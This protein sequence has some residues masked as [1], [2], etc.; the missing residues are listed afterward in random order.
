[1]ASSLDSPNT[2]RQLRAKV[3]WLDLL[4]GIEEFL[5]TTLASESL[6]L[7]AEEK[8]QYFVERLDIL[9]LPPSIPPRPG[10]RSAHGSQNELD[11][12][13]EATD[14]VPD[15]FAAYQ[16]ELARTFAQVPPPAKKE[17][18]SEHV[19]IYD[20]IDSS[21]SSHEEDKEH[22]LYEIPVVRQSDESCPPCS[23]PNDSASLATAASIDDITEEVADTCPP[24]PLPPRRDRTVSE[25]T[26]RSTESIASSG[27]PPDLP[28]RPLLHARNSDNSSVTEKLT[29]SQKSQNGVVDGDSTSYE[30]YDEEEK[31]NDVAL[32]NKLNIKLPK[33][34]KKESNR[35]KK[36]LSSSRSSNQ[37]ELN[38]PYKSLS[39]VV[40]SGDLYYRGKLSWNR[41][42]VALVN[43]NLVC[44]KPDK[45]TRPNLVIH[46]PGYEATCT[47]RDSKKGFEIKLS[48]PNCDA[49]YFS[50]DF[51][52]WAQTWCDNINKMSRG[53]S[54]PGSH[55]HLARSF[56]GNND[57][58]YPSF[59]GSKPELNSSNS[60]ISNASSDGLNEDAKR[61]K[62]RGNK[63]MRMGS[64]AYRATQF[65]ENLGKKP[66]GKRKSEGI[67][68]DLDLKAGIEEECSQ[69]SSSSGLPLLTPSSDSLEPVFADLAPPVSSLSGVK[70]A[71]YLEVFSSFN[72]R[73]WGKRYCL[74]RDNTFECYKTEQSKACELSFL[75]KPCVMRQAIAETQSNF[76]LMLL[77]SG[78]EKITVEVGSKNEMAVWVTVLMREMANDSVPEGLEEYLIED[79]RS[80]EIL[81]DKTDFSD[82]LGYSVIQSWD[83]ANEHYEDKKPSEVVIGEGAQDETVIGDLYTQV[84]KSSSSGSSLLTPLPGIEENAE[85]FDEQKLTSDSGFV[86]VHGFNSDSES[87]SGC[88]VKSEDESRTY[89]GKLLFSTRQERDSTSREVTP[90]DSDS[91]ERT[92]V[93]AEETFSDCVT[94]FENLSP[95]MNK[96]Q[97]DN[98]VANE[99]TESVLVD[100]NCNIEK[101]LEIEVDDVKGDDSDKVCVDVT[102]C[103]SVADTNGPKNSLPDLDHKVGIKDLCQCNVSSN[104]E[105]TNQDLL[106][107]K[108][109]IQNLIKHSSEL[110]ETEKSSSTSISISEKLEHNASIVNSSEDDTEECKVPTPSD[111]PNSLSKPKADAMSQS[112]CENM[113]PCER[114]EPCGVEKDGS[115]SEA[116][117]PVD[118]KHNPNSTDATE[119]QV[120]IKRLREKLIQIKRKRIAVNDKRKRVETDDEKFVCDEEYSLL[121]DQCKRIDLEL[122]QLTDALSNELNS[123]ILS[124]ESN[125]GTLSNESNSGTLSNELNSGILSNESNSEVL[126]NE[127]HLDVVH[128]QYTDSSQHCVQ[129]DNKSS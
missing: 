31:A 53:L 113:A 24:P 46:L 33:R 41:R 13:D 76:S 19:K 64:F 105:A 6:S 1:M 34:A 120:R 59:G 61:P 50:V 23:Q 27:K 106:S 91:R 123:G 51:K 36:K 103:E 2:L 94:D 107:V 22:D 92:L 65:F 8:R 18:K 55:Q 35:L 71:G 114:N 81:H 43:G 129:T 80:D 69:S 83:L 30:S 56:I 84:V 128:E 93:E 79:D 125:S 14:C 96:M 40:L 88:A 87:D 73:R 16:R 127:S 77:E 102:S 116:S 115:G 11:D 98:I 75:L 89:E 121:E 85:V 124:N 82:M 10:R 119:I 54:V 45:E 47:E 118:S 101:Q 29:K 17:T 70:H 122:S 68:K 4:P 15:D 28:A 86:S 97:S 74:V 78:K 58:T 7:A 95:G 37:W 63:V 66:S 62:L 49:H 48:H 52:E 108:D 26:N 117:S 42:Q 25:T 109:S 32:L 126:S 90:F 67:Y 99:K 57:Q 110:T 111:E 38:V 72:K 9:K 5:V 21:E 3:I 112:S 12:V 100:K 20:D 104:N 44:Y 60:N 39:D